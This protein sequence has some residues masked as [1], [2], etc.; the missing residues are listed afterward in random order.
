MGLIVHNPKGHAL[1]RIENHFLDVSLRDNDEKAFHCA[2]LGR[3]AQQRPHAGLD[4]LTRLREID[5]NAAP[6]RSDP[7][8]RR[9]EK[10]PAGVKRQGSIESEPERIFFFDRGNRAIL[11]LFEP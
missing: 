6:A 1:R 3:D 2:T 4:N 8:D 5:D 11:I 10:Q 7:L 9:R